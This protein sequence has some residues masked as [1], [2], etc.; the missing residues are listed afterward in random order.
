MGDF[1]VVND[2][3]L[4]FFKDKFPA[5]ATY[6]VAGLPKAGR[7]EI[8]SIAIIGDIIDST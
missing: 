7:V 5:R 4:S 6:Q 3:Y 2:V 8:E 1:P